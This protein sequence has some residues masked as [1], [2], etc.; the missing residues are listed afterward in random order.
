MKTVGMIM[1]VVML[2]CQLAAEELMKK[3]LMPFFD[4]VPPPPA[5]AQE[6]FTKITINDDGALRFSAEKVYGALQKEVKEMETVLAQQM[7]SASMAAAPPGVPA[8]TGNQM[9]DPEMNENGDGNDE[10]HA[11]WIH[12]AAAGIPSHPE[13]PGRMAESLQY[14]WH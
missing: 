14:A 13:C 6:A 11:G 9:P 1:I 7:K 2:F 10:V 12:D 3:D 8:G 5:T 4:N